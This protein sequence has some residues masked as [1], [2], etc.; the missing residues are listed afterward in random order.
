MID[1]HCH[2]QDDKLASALEQVIG[3]AMDRGIDTFVVNG[4]SEKDWD[5]VADLARNHRQ[6]IPFFG[7]HP[8]FVADRSVDWLQRL[9]VF[10]DEFPDAGVGEIGLDR[11][12][13]N[14]DIDQQMPVFESQWQLANEKGRPICV[15]CLQAWG[16]LEQ[17]LRSLPGKNFLLH[18]YSGSREM[19]PVF[20]KLG[21]YF[22]ISGYFLKPEKSAKLEIFDSVSDDRLL[23]ETDAPEMG[24]PP[25]QNLYPGENFN[26]PANLT[27]VYE[28]VARRIGMSK[29]EL[30]SLVEKNFRNWL[31]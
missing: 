14:H 25:E 7:L 6:I 20:S 15:H 30:S 28:A 26:H 8:W 24:L 18:S 29:S 23:L 13:K 5:R 22:S 1:A 27:V 16:H 3:E 31:N 2:L 12:I 17:C 9:T 21:G 4:T 19:V 10:L 11:W